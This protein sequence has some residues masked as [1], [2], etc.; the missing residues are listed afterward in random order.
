MV[1]NDDNRDIIKKTIL[2]FEGD[3][4]SDMSIPRDKLYEIM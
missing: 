4:S 1:S 3:L 2:A